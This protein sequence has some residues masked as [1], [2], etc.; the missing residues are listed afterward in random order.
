MAN[1]R[2]TPIV[3]FD[4]LCGLCN[5]FVDFALARDRRGR[6]RFA[7][8]Q[9]ETAASL[10][11]SGGAPP[12]SPVTYGPDADPLRSMLLWENGVLHRKSDAALRVLGGLGGPWALARLLL[13]VPRF[14][15]DAVYDFVARNRYRWFG[16]RETCRMPSPAE[17][18]RFLP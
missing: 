3:L 2:E 12:A 13:A 18:K 8:L 1:P 11:E 14:L 4:G 17:R 5:G 7:A 6:Y 9:G 15:R 10:R 16:K